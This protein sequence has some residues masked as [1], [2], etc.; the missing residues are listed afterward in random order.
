MKKNVIQLRQDNE[1]SL[2]V[3]Q[4]RKTP[5]VQVACEKLNIARSTYYRWRQSDDHF[6]KDAD[7]ALVEGN[8][9]INDMAESQL[10][11]AIKDKNITAMIFWLKHH[12]PAYTTRVELS[13]ELRSRQDPLTP[14][15]EAIVRNALTLGGL[16]PPA[17]L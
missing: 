1:K 8:L 14:E 5:I 2:L 6:L 12:H 10:I 17:E 3:D 16:I 13:G 9:L 15:Q 4:L 7:Q 11:S